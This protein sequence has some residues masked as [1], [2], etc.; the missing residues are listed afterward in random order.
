[1]VK[2]FQSNEGEWK[3]RKE[4]L[5][6]YE[7]YKKITGDINATEIILKEH[8][9][10]HNLPNE[11]TEGNNESISECIEPESRHIESEEDK[12]IR[13]Q[14]N[15]EINE[16]KKVESKGECSKQM[17]IE[18]E[19]ERVKE[20]NNPKEPL[21]KDNDLI[22]F[23]FEE[24]STP[25][26]LVNH[27]LDK[28]CSSQ[29]SD[30]ITSQKIANVKRQLLIDGETIPTPFKNALFWPKTEKKDNKRRK[31]EKIPFVATSEQW[32]QYHLKKEEAKLEKER[33]KMARAEERLKK[34]EDR[35]NLKK[36][37]E[38]KKLEMKANKRK[39]KG[40]KLHQIQ[41]NQRNG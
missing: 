10:G 9:N 11:H 41:K 14:S 28:A 26:A 38:Q 22:S 34:K 39:K 19:E 17:N 13:G 15:E 27:T 29:N 16:P 32:Q 31:K 4:D 40:L 12:I 18:Y 25:I 5:A 6:L 30:P 37:N 24:Q 3:G 8:N 21:H 2:N 1:M 23:A 33:Q 7:F 36:I 35:M 20:D